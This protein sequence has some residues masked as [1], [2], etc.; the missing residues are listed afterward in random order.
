MATVEAHIRVVNYDLRV[1]LVALDIGE[2]VQAGE[3]V[4]S[5]QVPLLDP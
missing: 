1:D 4:G 5:L 2:V 3:M